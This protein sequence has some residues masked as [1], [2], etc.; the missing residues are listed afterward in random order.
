MKY[1]FFD[2]SDVT[3]QICNIKQSTTIQ[4]ILWRD[5]FSGS[6][7]TLDRILLVANV[8]KMLQWLLI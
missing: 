6:K 4:I 3:Y 2:F 8:K 7:N 5:Q 1:T